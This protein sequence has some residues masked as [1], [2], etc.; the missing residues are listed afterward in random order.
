MVV[1]WMRL[2]GTGQWRAGRSV[3]SRKGRF[4]FN[5]TSRHYTCIARM[6][7]GRADYC[8]RMLVSTRSLTGL[9]VS[10]RRTA[11]CRCRGPSC[12]ATTIPP[13][14]NTTQV[15]IPCWTLHLLSTAPPAVELG[16]LLPKSSAYVLVSQTGSTQLKDLTLHTEPLEDAQPN[17]TK[18]NSL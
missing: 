17:T 4:G 11:R 2:Q 15:S 3:V 9:S 8:C 18:R 6:L 14:L 10:S 16:H 12:R 5:T 7:S 13:E 1:G